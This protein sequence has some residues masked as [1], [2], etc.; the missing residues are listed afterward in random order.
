[1]SESGGGSG[2]GFIFGGGGGGD[3]DFLFRCSAGGIHIGHS[4]G[5]GGELLLF[6][7]WDGPG[8]PADF[9]LA[10]ALARFLVLR[11]L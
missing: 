8:G 9:A 2:G 6:L 4:G 11:Y 5:G 10:P 1:M 3:A 7:G